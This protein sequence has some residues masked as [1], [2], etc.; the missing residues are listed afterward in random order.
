MLVYVDLQQHKVCVTTN[1][2]PGEQRG[3]PTCLHG[4]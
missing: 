1:E 4:I 2:D 3:S